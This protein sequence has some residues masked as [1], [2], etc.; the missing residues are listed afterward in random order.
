[1]Y[2]KFKKKYC[3]LIGAFINNLGGSFN[4]KGMPAINI[5]VIGSNYEKAGVKIAFFG[6]ETN[7]WH[8]FKEFFEM[9]AGDGA[10]KAYHFLTKAT[11]PIFHKE[12]ADN[13][14]LSF[15]RYVTDFLDIFYSLPKFSEIPRILESFIWGNTNS[16]ER[17]E[18]S[19]K[20]K[21]AKYEYWEQIKKA[22]KIFDTAEHVLNIC[23]PDILLVMDKN[24]DENWFT[25]NK[26]I[27]HIELDSLHWYYKVNK[28]HVY[29]L[30]H[31]EFT[32]TPKDTNFEKSIKLIIN[33]YEKRQKKSGRSLP[34]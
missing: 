8:S 27:K 31:P 22:S 3:K 25:G 4:V 16:I 34:D 21:G 12:L 7:G 15:W 28:T 32:P 14:K 5:P 26:A 18:T 11:N 17:Y 29:W 1:M 19:A 30:P 24:I 20:L 6:K 33:D 10:E 2:E 13:T 23:K 9:C